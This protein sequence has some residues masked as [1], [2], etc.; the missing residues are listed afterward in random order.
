MGFG[1]IIKARREELGITQ[2]AAAAELG[3]SRP[4]LCQLERGSKAPSLP[5]ALQL[6]KLLQCSLNELCGEGVKK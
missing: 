4:M 5:L 3:I 6:A 2:A 1:E